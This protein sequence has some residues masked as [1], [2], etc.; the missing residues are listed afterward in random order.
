[1]ATRP[2]QEPRIQTLNRNQTNAWRAEAKYWEGKASYAAGEMAKSANPS[3]KKM[4]Q[5]ARTHAEACAHY[6]LTRASNG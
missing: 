4:H 5:E 1:M 3:T 2:D 6:C